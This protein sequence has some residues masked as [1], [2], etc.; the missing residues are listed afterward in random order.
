M[1]GKLFSLTS[2]SLCSTAILLPVLTTFVQIAKSQTGTKVDIINISKLERRPL[3]GHKAKVT[4]K[5][6]VPEKFSLKKIEGTIVFKLLDNKKQTGTF[7][8]DNPK[9]ENT[10]ELNALGELL[11]V[12]QQP[13]SVDVN[14]TATV[15]KIF[16]GTTN[17]TF[18]PD[19]T[20][21]SQSD[22]FDLN[23]DIPKISDFKR[24]AL[25][26]HQVRVHYQTPSV[27]TGFTAKKLLVTTTFNLNNSQTQ[28]DTVSKDNNIALNGSEL[29][30][31]NGKVFKKEGEVV[32]IAT[33][34]NI[35]G[36]ITDTN[37]GSKSEDCING[38]ECIN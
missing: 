12:D 25:G 11:A 6:T 26:G 35:Q 31:T 33:K 34:V 10:I 18:R 17:S 32:G 22:A 37:T 15:E 2:V 29:L 38:A 28:T 16:N 27:P 30:D 1:F 3:G 13:K 8:I 20:L 5:V 23:I 7:S 4:Y 24:Q 14:M 19:G 9:R 21:I 36:I